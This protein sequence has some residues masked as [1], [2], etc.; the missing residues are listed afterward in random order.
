[1]PDLFIYHK[2]V[3]LP[4]RQN[5]PLTIKCHQCGREIIRNINARGMCDGCFKVL[6]SHA[7]FEICH[8]SDGYEL[9]PFV[10]KG[11]EL[12]PKIL[13][14]RELWGISRISV[15]KQLTI[16]YVVF[17][18]RIMELSSSDPDSDT[19]H[20][21][22][23]FLSDPDP[24]PDTDHGIMQFLSDP[25][26]DS[27]HGI[28]QLSSDPDTDSD[29]GMLLSSLSEPDTDTDHGIIQSSSSSSSDTDTE[30][31]DI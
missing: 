24:D 1:M 28:M 6:C 3:E 19:D 12:L 14:S 8:G 17:D 2:W 25:D 26:P 29:H 13:L 30:T 7:C 16:E 22:M 27:D 23:Q 20:G 4:P 15:T 5:A 21:I 31:Y 11:R 10:R 18:H 9:L